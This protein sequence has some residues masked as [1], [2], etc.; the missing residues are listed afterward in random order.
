MKKII[1]LVVI[2]IVAAAG[3]LAYRFA[4]K[5]HYIDITQA[6]IQQQLDPRFPLEKNL[7]V[8]RLALSHPKVLLKEGSDRIDFSVD[9]I[10]SVPGQKDYKGSAQ[11]SG[12]VKYNPERG[13][14]FLTD[15]KVE[16]LNIPGLAGGNLDKAREF[17]SI[18]IKE[19]LERF[20]LYKLDPKNFQE[21]VAKALLKSVKVENGKLRITLG[22]SR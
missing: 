18:L 10:A 4:V 3:F 16:S 15:S 1:I 17:S 6:E 2:A 9:A 5:D 22:I 12:K 7:L 13:D 11:L 14:F 20:S 8:F 21:S 19:S